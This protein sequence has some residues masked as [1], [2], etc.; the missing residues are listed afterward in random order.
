MDE[1][2]DARVAVAWIVGTAQHIKKRLDQI[3]GVKD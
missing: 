2:V 1:S 3:A